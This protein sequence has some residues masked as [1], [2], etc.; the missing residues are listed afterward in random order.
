MEPPEVRYALTKDGYR[1]AWQQW[2][3]GPEVFVVPPLVS[4]VEL[5]WEQELFRRAFE[6]FGDHVRMTAFDKRGI[7]LSDQF[8]EPPTLEQRCEDILAVMDAAKLERPTL[9]GLSEGGL[10]AQLFTALH[11]GRVDRLVLG[12]SHP[13][14]SA[15]VEL[16][17]DL[18]DKIRKFRRMTDHWGTDIQWFVEWFNPSQ[19]D[20]AAFVRWMGRYARLSATPASIRR[21]VQSIST[22]DA[23]DHLSQI[24]APTLVT[25]VAEDGVIPPAAGP[26]LAERIPDATFE[27]LGGADHFGLAD[28]EWRAQADVH[29]EF[30]CGSVSTSHTEKRLATIVFT[31]I[32][33]S[34]ER[35]A[36]EGDEQWRLTL[37][38]HD[39]IGW[40]AANH[41][42]GVLVKNTGDGL[43]LRF[44]S[45]ADAFD[46]AREVRHELDSVGLPIRCGLHTGQIELR[47]NGDIS[48]VA[49]NLAKRVE[50]AAGA[51]QILVSSTVRDVMLGGEAQ[52]EDRG[53]HTLKGFDSPW[54]LY[55][56]A[57]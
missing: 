46:F 15:F 51:G 44:E 8:S 20:N 31:D 7:G 41:H 43:L 3:S 4:N 50:E 42:R 1:L 55:E 53:E 16:E 28:P 12:N 52:L 48:G 34:T 29:L 38:S 45:P 32:V 30:I 33:G 49:V 18:E 17:P 5:V 25:H 27:Q 19:A 56:L 14:A 40:A 36:S 26:W 11:P 24:A 54:R 39:R 9:M 35:S 2:G 13:G 10:M 47:A 21:Q 57:G 23:R 22:L 6:Y 37:D